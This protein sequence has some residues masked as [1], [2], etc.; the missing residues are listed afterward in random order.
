MCIRDRPQMQQHGGHRPG[1]QRPVREQLQRRV[2]RNP[3][4]R[5]LRGR[6]QVRRRPQPQ[7][8]PPPH[9][10]S[11]G[12]SD[13]QPDHQRHTAGPAPQEGA[14]GTEHAQPQRQ[15]E[16]GAV[17]GDP[18]LALRGAQEHGLPVGDVL[19]PGGQPQ[20]QQAEEQ[21]G[22]PEEQGD[23][24]PVPDVLR[25]D[26]PGGGSRLLGRER[27]RVEGGRR[28]LGFGHPHIVPGVPGSGV[29]GPCQRTAA[30]R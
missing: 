29:G 9:Q 21:S 17:G 30:R 27:R 24:G 20:P 2:E 25:G 23:D 26:R 3:L 16:E 7:P 1:Q 6:E 19:H 28:G 15:Q 11:E 8:E 4:A 22:R 12:G 5:L 14:D 10:R 13:R 18:C